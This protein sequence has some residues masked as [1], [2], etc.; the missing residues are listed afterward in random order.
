M[1]DG[2]STR[3]PHLT[4]PAIGVG[5]DFLELVLRL[6][7][8]LYDEAHLAGHLGAYTHHVAIDGGSLLVDHPL[9]AVRMREESLDL[10]R[11]RGI[12]VVIA[13]RDRVQHAEVLPDVVFLFLVQVSQELLAAQCHHNVTGLL[14]VHIHKR[15]D[16]HIVGCLQLHMHATAELVGSHLVLDEKRVVPLTVSRL[17]II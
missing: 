3:P 13:F 11:L 12:I 2:V 7:E 9:D 10:R 15:G 6:V 4:L 1:V 16:A 14:V 8:L 17:I 5:L